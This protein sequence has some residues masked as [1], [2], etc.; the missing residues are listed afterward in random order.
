MRGARRHCGV[1]AAPRQAAPRKSAEAACHRPRCLP[2]PFCCPNAGC[3]ACGASWSASCAATRLTLT[4]P[5]YPPVAPTHTPS[6]Y[7]RWEGCPSVKCA[8]HTP[9]S[10]GSGTLHRAQSCQHPP[11]WLINHHKGGALAFP[12]T[13][14]CAGS[15]TRPPTP[16]DPQATNTLLDCANWDS[17]RAVGVAT[18]HPEPPSHASSRITHTSLTLS[19]LPRVH[20]ALCPGCQTQVLYQTSQLH[21]PH[22]ACTPPTQDKHSAQR[23]TARVLPPLCHITPRS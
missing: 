7:K 1:T 5:G 20:V 13:K 16:W 10:S 11:L 3:A 17:L 8:A 19:P 12:P 6:V 4:L 21:T 22:A 23:S 15:L 9:S 14:P 18:L 2:A